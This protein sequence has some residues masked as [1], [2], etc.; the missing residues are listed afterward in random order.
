M[1]SLDD[2]R[3]KELD[4]RGW[5]SGVRSSLDPDAPFVPDELAKLLDAPSDLERF[6]SLWPYLCSEGTAWDA[7][8]AAVPYAVELARRLPPAQRFEYLYF[9]G[10]VV[11]RS[12]GVRFEYLYFAGLVV[13][14]S[15]GVGQGSLSWVKPYLLEGY[16]RA[17]A[18]ALP[19]LAETLVCPQDP[20]ETRYL[21][22]A[23]AAF[24]GNP[25]LGEV[26]NELHSICGQC[27]RCGELVYPDEFQQLA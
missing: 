13:I 23:A 12:G 6:G 19:L 1:L 16:Q 11:I 7:A 24:K 25:E 20:T 14:R 18:E 21:L 10:L 27:P 22:A 5:S 4:H 17:V 3:W 9:A 8:Y 26:L 2:P 15:G